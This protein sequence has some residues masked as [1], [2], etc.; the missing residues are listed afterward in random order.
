[1][2]RCN[3]PGSNQLMLKYHDEEWGV[4]VH[5]DYKHYEFI[6]LDG[7]QAGLRAEYTYRNIVSDESQEMSLID[8]FDYFP[9]LHLSYDIAKDFQ[10]M[11]S[12]SR[13]IERPRGWSF[14]PY[15]VWEDAYNVRIGNPKLIPEYTDSYE[16]GLIKKFD[17]NFIS[18]ESFYRVTHN[19]IERIRSIYS[20]DVFLRT[21]MNVG[22][23]K[24]IESN[25]LARNLIQKPAKCTP[26]GASGAA[27]S[28]L[29]VFGASVLV[30]SSAFF[31]AGIFTPQSG[32]NSSSASSLA[33]HSGQ[34]FIK[35]TYYTY[36]LI[37]VFNI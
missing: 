20:D 12:Y 1:M 4:P 28:A 2:N 31:P 32:Q 22:T 23:E 19:K 11:A 37:I 15:L 6:L 17:K 3:W 5:D 9:S 16:F 25:N 21:I 13:R 34:Y 30:F 36:Y 35:I 14:E 24:I 18:L 7:F 29:D 33:P 10:T 27:F 8:R 26:E